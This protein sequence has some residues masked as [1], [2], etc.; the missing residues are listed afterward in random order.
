MGKTPKKTSKFTT[1]IINHIKDNL[2]EYIIVSL[3]LLIG[4][5]VGVFFVNNMNESQAQEV[6]VYLTSF[7]NS[8]KDGASIN[9][10]KL[11]QKSIWNNLVLS[12]L[13][14]LIGSTVIGFP[15]VIGMVAFRGFCLGYTISSSIAIWGAYKGTLFFITNILLQN[16][17]F[18]PA[19]I[20][21]AVSGIKMYKSIMKDKHRENIKLEILRHT[22]FSLIMLAVL[23]LSSFVEAYISPILFKMYMPYL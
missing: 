5:V 11:L 22:I 8:L 7:T 1:I 19:I 6:E 10:G 14:W 2:K 16:I 4:I 18:I 3:I 9:Q 15:L 23:I 17:L 13:M 20:A 21:L 12:I